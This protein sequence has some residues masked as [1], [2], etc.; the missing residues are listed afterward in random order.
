MKRRKFITAGLA[1][2]VVLFVNPSKVFGEGYTIEE[3][4]R[5]GVSGSELLD[6]LLYLGG[7]VC[8]RREDLRLREKG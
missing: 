5:K 3:F 7:L 4:S 6:G 1:T 2:G 8:C